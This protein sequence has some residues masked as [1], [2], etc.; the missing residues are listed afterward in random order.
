MDGKSQQ[1]LCHS[2][3]PP[4]YLTSWKACNLCMA[5]FFAL[6]AYVQIN[7]PDAGI[8]IVAYLIPAAL[9]FLV[10]LNPPITENF[11]WKSLSAMHMYV[12]STVAI[13]WGWYLRGA[14]NNIFHE[15]EGREFLGLVIIAIWMLLCR[16]SGD[17]ISLATNIG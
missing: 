3:L 15:E 9:T 17:L 7:D 5:F 14:K 13:L 11:I 16:H 2:A 8:W 1:H 12:C 4:L 10:G 6:A